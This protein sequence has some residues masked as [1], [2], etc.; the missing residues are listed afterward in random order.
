MTPLFSGKDVIIL[1]ILTAV[2]VLVCALA[3][4]GKF[5]DNEDI[6]DKNKRRTQFMYGIPTYWMPVAVLIVLLITPF[7]MIIDQAV[8]YR[9]LGE[10]FLNVLPVMAL[11]MTL[12]SYFMPSMKKRLSA[13]SCVTIWLLPNLLYLNF[14][15]VRFYTNAPDLVIRMPVYVLTVLLLVWLTG[16]SA[17]MGSGFMEHHRFKKRLFENAYDVSDHIQQI[18]REERQAVG[19]ICKSDNLP[20]GALQPL[21]PVPVISPY[22]TSPLAIGFYWRSMRVV[23][24]EKNYTDE[25]LRL[26]FR[27]ELIHIVRKDSWTKLFLQMCRAMC[28]FLPF[29]WKA[30]EDAAEEIE[31]SCDEMVMWNEK[32]DVRNEYGRLILSAAS[33]SAGF[34]TCLSASAESMKYRL[35]RILKP[36]K[37]S[38]GLPVIALA[39]LLLACGSRVGTFAV[40]YGTVAGMLEK[41]YGSLAGYKLTAVYDK[42]NENILSQKSAAEWRTS[43]SGMRIYSMGQHYSYNMDG[44]RYTLV[45]ESVVGEAPLNMIITDHSFS[46]DTSKR[47]G[48]WTTVYYLDY[49]E[50]FF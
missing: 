14:M 16:F 31:L 10:L 49:A 34:T 11:Y 44:D 1:M 20:D 32:E 42:G 47:R 6:F 12:L 46:I 5:P 3:I 19:I 25:E 50:G 23:L 43:F 30:A 28:W 24:P 27:H 40:E 48:S 18:Y 36:E 38:M 26:I 21:L 37:R 29:A 9:I 8:S 4:S 22:I 41:E 17:V 2:V 35:T 15:Y 45:Y 7:S 33:Y 39:F 13:T